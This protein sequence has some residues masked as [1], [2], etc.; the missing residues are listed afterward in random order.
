MMDDIYYTTKEANEVCDPKKGEGFLASVA[1]FA[2][3]TITF[4]FMGLI[5]LEM[6][7]FILVPDVSIFEMFGLIG[8]FILLIGIPLRVFLWERNGKINS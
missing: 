3:L 6:L 1:K 7:R 5:A 8:V 4:G 2:V